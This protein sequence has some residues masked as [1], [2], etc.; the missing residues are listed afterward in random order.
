MNYIW[1]K[2]QMLSKSFNYIIKKQSSTTSTNIWPK[3]TEL[4]PS[5]SRAAL[6]YCSEYVIRLAKF[7]FDVKSRVLVTKGL[8][9]ISQWLVNRIESTQKSKKY[10]KTINSR[11]EISATYQ[12]S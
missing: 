5:E 2:Q 6:K 4:F 1:N 12:T 10:S 8:K 9:N 11:Q 3:R 7:I